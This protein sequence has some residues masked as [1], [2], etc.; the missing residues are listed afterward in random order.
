MEPLQLEHIWNRDPGRRRT[1]T[2]VRTCKHKFK[3]PE[4]HIRRRSAS[5]S[6]PRLYLW[7]RNMSANGLINEGHVLAGRTGCSKYL[8][9]SVTVFQPLE[10]LGFPQTARLS[11]FR[12]SIQKALLVPASMSL[13]RTSLQYFLSPSASLGKPRSLE[14]FRKLVILSWKLLIWVLPSAAGTSSFPVR[15]WWALKELGHRFENPGRDRRFCRRIR[16]FRSLLGL[17]LNINSWRC[18]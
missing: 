7:N 4:A 18:K 12:S 9:A 15:W 1:F 13:R 17:F 6:S 11:L 2:A 5:G 14:S 8:K 3:P 10:S 16:T